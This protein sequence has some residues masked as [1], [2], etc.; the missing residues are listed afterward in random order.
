MADDKLFPESQTNTDQ[1]F[2]DQPQAG[3]APLDPAA[4]AS[5]YLESAADSGE[6]NL[7]DL[8]PFPPPEAST[9]PKIASPA[10]SKGPKAASKPKPAD[11]KGRLAAQPAPDFPSE[12]LNLSASGTAAGAPG[13]ASPAATI[14]AADQG[15]MTIIFVGLKSFWEWLWSKIAAIPP[16]DDIFDRILFSLGLQRRP[17]GMLR[18][19]NTLAH[20][21]RLAEAVKWYRDYLALRPLS[22][23]GYD[24]LGRVYFR[25]GLS[26]EAD[27]EFVI[28]DSMERILHN[29]D[30]IDAAAALAEAFLERKQAKISVS[31]I[32]PVLIAHFYTPGNSQLLKTMGRV[33]TEMRSTKKMYQVYEA[34]LA[35]YPDDYEFHILKGNAEI[36]M[37]NVAEGERLIRWGRLMKKLKENPRDANAKM[38]MGEIFIKEQ[39]QDE[40]LRQLRE[41]AALL[42]DNPGIRWR[43]FNLYQK[44]GNY[45]E[46]LKYFLEIAAMEPD[47]EDLKYRLAD[48]YRKNKHREEALSIYEEMADKHPREPKPRALMGDLMNEMGNFEEGQQMKELA[49]T[50]ECGLKAN[51]DHKETVRFMK[52]LFSIGANEEARQWLERGLAKW[53]YHG[54]LVLTKVKLLYNE[55]RYKDAVG[56]LKRLISVK[57]DVA[58]PHIWIAM[59]YQ[60][61]G[62]NM[63]ALAESQLATRLA[64]KSYTAHK[65]LGD[66]LKEQKK[67][68]QA[69]AAYEVAE[70]MRHVKK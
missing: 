59:C 56:L 67:L 16:I 8:S 62:D 11:P 6:I 3:G 57:P 58:E 51:P 32:E 65:V 39:K 49:Q 47:N 2:Q 46:S 52:Y 29:R 21:G 10:K 1:L 60:R 23:A 54:E 5:V 14:P 66:I 45:E 26:E 43:L 28:A 7:D 38:A 9:P 24:G 27:R 48:F 61:L 36:K 34:G 68:S 41:A 33:Y 37:G 19:A 20:K 15:R 18:R 31:L 42:P 17:G 12:A 30:D 64:P 40:G 69:N 4:G 53:P 25:M 55:Y 22:V 70:M 50:L 63:A 35:Q 13:T 44:Q